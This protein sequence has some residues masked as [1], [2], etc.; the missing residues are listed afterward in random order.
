MR[1]QLSRTFASSILFSKELE[2]ISGEVKTGLDPYGTGKGDRAGVAPG[3]GASGPSDRHRQASRV[4]FPISWPGLSKLYGQRRAAPVPA[5]A[6]R[7]A[8]PRQA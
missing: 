8:H 4:G 3:A 1:A 7:M 2:D 5:V 6:F